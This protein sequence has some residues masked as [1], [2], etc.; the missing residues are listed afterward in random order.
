MV[1]SNRA[2]MK[3]DTDDIDEEKNLDNTLTKFDKNSTNDNDF[4]DSDEILRILFKKS[5]FYKLKLK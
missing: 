1:K 5:H 2:H 4:I 3:I